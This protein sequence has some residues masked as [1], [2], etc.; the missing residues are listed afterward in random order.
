MTVT[1]STMNTSG[2]PV[3]AGPLVAGSFL[4][5]AFGV[6]KA[7][8]LSA[9]VLFP[10]AV[11][12]KIMSANGRSVALGSGDVMKEETLSK[13]SW[14]ITATYDQSRRQLTFLGESG[15]I[16]S[17]FVLTFD[18]K[19]NV[20]SVSGGPF[21]EYVLELVLGLKGGGV[22]TPEGFDGLKPLIR[23]MSVPSVDQE[24]PPMFT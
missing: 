2:L 8:P 23:G 21:R 1:K 6:N 24:N 12:D 20:S 10:P 14:Q 5:P 18:S 16:F 22:F 7:L 19:G 3:G 17:T 11:L 15:V 13:S 9:R 4:P